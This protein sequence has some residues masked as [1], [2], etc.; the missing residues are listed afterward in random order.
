M[1]IV[2]KKFTTIETYFISIK[3]SRI[4]EIERKS[5]QNKKTLLFDDSFQKDIWQ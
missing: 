2:I 5:K 4:I 1:C 3:E